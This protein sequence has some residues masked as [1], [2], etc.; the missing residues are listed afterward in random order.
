MLFKKTAAFTSAYINMGRY[1]LKSNFL[2]VS[3][4]R[5]SVV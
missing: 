5:K 2:I 1:I 4:D 3:L